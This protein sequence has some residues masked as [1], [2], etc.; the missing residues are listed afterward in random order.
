MKALDILFVYLCK[1][2]AQCFCCTISF[3]DIYEFQAAY[4]AGVPFV[5]LMFFHAGVGFL[6]FLNCYFTTPGEPI[7]G[8]D[9]LSY[10]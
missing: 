4:D 8:P 10:A 3:N 9:D 2:L 6:T 7:P 5:A 1:N